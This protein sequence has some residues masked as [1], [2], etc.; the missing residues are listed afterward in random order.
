[1]ETCEICSVKCFGVDDYHG[2]CCSIEN[3][4]WILGGVGDHKDFLQRLR[5][6]FGSHIQHSDVFVEYEEGKNLF[7]GNVCWEN[8][9]LYPALRVNMN[10]EMKECIFYNKNVRKCMVYDIRPQMCKDFYCEYLKEND[11]S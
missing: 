10:S 6:K 4:T 2:S 11:K 3:R 7:P 9:D 5:T 8:P 1:M